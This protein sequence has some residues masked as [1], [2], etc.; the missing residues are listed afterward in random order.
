[1]PEQLLH[2]YARFRGE[3]FAR[4]RDLL[5][6]LATHGQKPLAL[7]IGCS[8]SRVIPELLT[9]TGPGGLFVVRNV[10]NQVPELKHPDA[11]VGAAI[12]YGVAVLKVRHIIVCGHYGCGGV[13]ATIDGRAA[14]AELPS[15]HE[16]LE[17]VEPAVQ[18]MREAGLAG[19]AG[20][21]RAV[22]E[23]VLLQIDNLISFGP[24][25][26]AL[27]ADALSL[28]GWIYDI[29]SAQLSIY[30]TDGDDFTTVTDLAPQTA[31]P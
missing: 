22:E 18:R 27:E 28:H 3:Y 26:R 10:A 8:D 15:L 29:N 6:N 11:S 24:V 13:K 12:E 30:D 17:G 19:E 25:A 20:F 16:W 23:N 31:L 4:E 1:M 5:H 21:R 7:F 2:G 9:T 14:V